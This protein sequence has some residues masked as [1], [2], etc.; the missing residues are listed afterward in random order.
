MTQVLPQQTGLQV[1]GVFYKYTTIKNTQDDM[2]VNV[3]NEN[4]RGTGY[5][6]RE[7]DDWSGRPGNTITKNVPVPLIDI[8][9]WGDGSIEVEGKGSVENP[10]VIYSYQYDPCNDPQSNPRCPGYKEPFSMDLIEVDVYDPLDDEMIQDELDRKANMKSQK[11]EEDRRARLKIAKEAEEGERELLETLLGIEGNQ[12]DYTSEQ[13]LL[14][15]SL[16][17]LKNIPSSYQ[18]SI[19]GGTYTD[20]VVLKDK[21][22]PENRSALKMNLKQDINHEK[23]VNLQYAK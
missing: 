22:L 11:E 9:F 14:H 7:S 23:L 5:I 16:M 15:N 12:N 17:A 2:I 6:F 20:A 3:Q 13:R 4:A 18:Y 1:N 21:K 19:D 8:G 10:E